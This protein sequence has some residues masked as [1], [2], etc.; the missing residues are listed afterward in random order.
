M[1]RNCCEEPQDKYTKQTTFT[2]QA[3]GGRWF[4]PWDTVFAIV[5]TDAIATL[6]SV[7]TR[8]HLPGHIAKA[9]RKRKQSGQKYQASYDSG[10]QNRKQASKSTKPRHQTNQVEEDDEVSIIYTLTDKQS[11]PKVT[12]KVAGALLTM[13]V[14]TGASRSM[15][16]IPAYIYKR[17]LTHVKL[18]KSIESNSRHTPENH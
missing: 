10:F 8:R 4:I 6:K 13:D 5:V 11:S 14:D 9:C 15:T 2:V 12:V 16:V 7:G 3:S 1:N 18:Q 17:I